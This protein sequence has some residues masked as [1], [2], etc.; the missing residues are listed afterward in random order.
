MLLLRSIDGARI[1][2]ECRNAAT[3]GS[4]LGSHGILPRL[5]APSRALP[6]ECEN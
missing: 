3:H 6:F 4:F 5:V 2:M 1:E